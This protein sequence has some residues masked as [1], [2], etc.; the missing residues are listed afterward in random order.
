M[1]TRLLTATLAVAGVVA[2]GCGDD[3]DTTSTAAEEAATATTTD[4]TS[5]PGRVDLATP[6]GNKFV[7]EPDETSVEAGRVTL[8]WDNE[9]KVEHSVCLED[10]QGKLVDPGCSSPFTQPLGCRRSTSRGPTTT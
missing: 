8:N 1:K 10:E 7:F 5:I 9:S 4:S 3:E 2:V 6:P